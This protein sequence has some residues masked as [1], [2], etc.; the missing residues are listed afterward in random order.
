LKLRVHNESPQA[1]ASSTDFVSSLNEIV[2][3]VSARLSASLPQPDDSPRGDPSALPSL[4]E[5]EDSDGGDG[6]ARVGVLEEVEL[7]ERGS[8]IEER[9]TRIFL[10]ATVQPVRAKPGSLDA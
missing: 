4:E 8:L 6:T 1:R 3:A 9:E 10:Q 2:E 5:D 7:D